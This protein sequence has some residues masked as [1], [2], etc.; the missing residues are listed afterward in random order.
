VIAFDRKG[1]EIVRTTVE[2]PMF[3]RSAA[4]QNSI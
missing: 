4:H 3:T 1:R 2:E